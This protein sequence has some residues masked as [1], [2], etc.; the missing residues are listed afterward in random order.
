[1]NI[2]WRQA[3]RSANGSKVFIDDSLQDGASIYHY[4]EYPHAL[5]MFS[6]GRLRLAN[7]IN[8]PDPYEQWWCKTLFDRTGPFHQTSAYVLSWSRSHFDEPAWRMAGFQR[9]NPII[10]I[11]CRVRDILAAASTLAQQRAGAFFT[12]KVCYEKEEELWRR[13]KSLRAG[14]MKDAPRLAAN[15]LLRKRT[16]F[17]FEK[18]VRTLWLDREPQ[19]TALFLPI[20]AK[21]IVR[22]VMCS[23]HTHP[24]Q[25]ARIRQEFEDRFA[26]KVTDSR[27]LHPPQV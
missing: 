4:L 27:S 21:A 18:E 1:M 13:A 22:Q 19:N 14:E 9:T 15:A 25:R 8:W 3:S 24:D 12:G 6:E 17:R 10:R 20:D 26:V 2:R 11:R 7:P 16:A 23:P 5:S